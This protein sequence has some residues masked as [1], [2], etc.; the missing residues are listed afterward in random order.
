MRWNVNFTSLL[1]TAGMTGR[2]DPYAI[3]V[4]AEDEKAGQKEIPCAFFRA[5]GF[6]RVTAASGELVW[7][8]PGEMAALESRP[9]WVYF[10]TVGAMPR[11]PPKYPPIPGADTKPAN[12]VRNPGFEQADP[13]DPTKPAEW[14]PS[15]SSGSTVKP[16]GTMQIVHEPV[17]SGKNALK[18]HCTEG[19]RFGCQQ[20][21][22]PMKPNALACPM[23]INSPAS[24]TPNTRVPKF[25]LLPLGSVNP[26]ITPSCVS[27]V[28][29]L[30][31]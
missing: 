2:F 23:N 3:R 16:K 12:A 8:I 26:A 20:Q 6:D 22:I 5:E 27:C 4:A 9:Y 21:K 17:R 19:Y 13:N 31:H 18:L 1:K 10:D 25:F 28:L 15:D 7:Q 11:K 29:T 24:N 14:T 30:S